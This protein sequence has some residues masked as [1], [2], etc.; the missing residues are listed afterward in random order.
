MKKI[1][2]RLIAILGALVGW[3]AIMAFLGLGLFFSG[4]QAGLSLTAL[5]CALFIIA[6]GLVM[7]FRE[8]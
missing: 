1:F 4:M 2:S 3:Q 8:E 5:A 6:I 7:P